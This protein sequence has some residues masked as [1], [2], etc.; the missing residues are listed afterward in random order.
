MAR[1]SREDYLTGLL[2]YGYDINT[3]SRR[4]VHH[5]LNERYSIDE[6]VLGVVPQRCCLRA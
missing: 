3:V 4:R 6:H 2:E 5:H 1:A